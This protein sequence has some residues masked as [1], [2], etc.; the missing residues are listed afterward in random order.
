MCLFIS[1][2]FLFFYGINIFL[3]YL[4]DA[5]RFERIA[6]KYYLIRDNM[7]AQQQKLTDLRIR[8]LSFI[9]E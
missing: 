2:F 5:Q 9:Q 7:K 1:S 4:I 6:C 3:I 8:L